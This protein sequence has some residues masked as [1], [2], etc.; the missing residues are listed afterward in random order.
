M[1]ERVTERSHLSIGEVLSLLRD[2]FPDVTISK[3]RFL[4]SQ[5]LVDPERT[6]SGYRKFYEHDVERLKWIL[7]Q[8]REHFL[9]L[10]VIRG[11]LSG[12]GDGTPADGPL[13]PEE[14]S[15]IPVGA[16]PFDGGSTAGSG[17]PTAPPSAPPPI[18]HQPEA[19]VPTGGDGPAP[20]DT[21]DARPSGAT[22]PTPPTPS[23]FAQLRG[24]RPTDAAASGEPPRTARRS[25]PPDSGRARL[26]ASQTG[27]GPAAASPAGAF[28]SARERAAPAAP[29]GPSIGAGTGGNPPPAASDG[30]DDEAQTF[31]AEEL[32]AAVGTDADIVQQLKQYGLITPSATVAGV[33]YY[34]QGSLA[35][36]LAAARFARHGVEAR[37]LRVWRN[38][39]EREADLYQ[40]VVLPLLRQRNPQARRQ[41]LDTL[42]ELAS[43]GAS[44]RAALVERA[45]R[46]IR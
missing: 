5:G 44:L 18:G 26:S 41:A 11:R 38:S 42:E 45:M 29:A 25:A 3:I 20:I 12:Q 32:A 1:A 14:A 43:A 37:H 15:A 30:S 31:T 40:Q 39:A 6:P 7:R 35:V 10:K 23:L 34:D 21:G 8:Q 28:P 16:D 13:T 33:A 2:E 36:V 19:A 27:P 9:P 24:D 46:D 22:R 4:E 17:A